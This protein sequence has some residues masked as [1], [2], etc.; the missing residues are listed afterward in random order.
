ML[1]PSILEE[2]KVLPS[3]CSLNQAKGCVATRIFST[4]DKLL[5]VNMGNFR[6]CNTDIVLLDGVNIIMDPYLDS[7]TNRS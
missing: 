6:Y 1:Y 7:L 4:I 5:S 2:K 3:I